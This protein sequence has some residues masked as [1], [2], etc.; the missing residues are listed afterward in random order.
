MEK[1]I[2]PKTYFIEETTKAVKI[3]R[4]RIEAAQSRQKSYADVRCRPLEFG[5]G[6]GVFIKVA[7]MKGVMGFGK[8]GK[9]SPRYVGPYM[10][11]KM[12]GKVAY[13]LELPQEMSAIHNVFHVSMLKKYISDPTHV[14]QPQVIKISEDLTYEEKPVEIVDRKIKKLRNKEIPLVKVIW[15]NHQVEE[16]TWEREEDMKEIYPVF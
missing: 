3:I 1:D 9:L 7:P 10:I 14:I 8:K 6:D 13:E 2:E 5:V 15:R 16:A 4:Q 12:I 11:K